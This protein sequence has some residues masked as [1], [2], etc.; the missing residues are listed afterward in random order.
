[1]NKNFDNFS[2]SIKENIL[3]SILLCCLAFFYFLTFF[4]HSFI[5]MCTTLEITFIEDYYK[6]NHLMQN[7]IE[8]YVKFLYYYFY[9][10]RAFGMDPFFCG[11]FN[12][13]QFLS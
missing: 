1:M 11:S 10:G 7:K 6:R 13:Q 12:C 2:S 4:F 3:I 9:D 5:E 8:I